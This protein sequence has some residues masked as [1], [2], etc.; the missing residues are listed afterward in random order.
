MN[1]IL[2]LWWAVC[3]KIQDEIYSRKSSFK[4][5]KPFK[6]AKT[7]S[8]KIQKSFK[9]ENHSRCRT[10]Q[11]LE[12]FSILNDFCI[13]NESFCNLERFLHLEWTFSWINF[14]LNFETKLWP[15]MCHYRIPGNFCWVKVSFQVLK[16]SFRGLIFVLGLKCSIEKYII[17][18]NYKGRFRELNR[19]LKY[20]SSALVG[21]SALH[22]S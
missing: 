10:I 15:T 11:D 22:W 17:L 12:C 19:G 9:I 4:M 5:P 21:N 8:F 3:F 14:I 1:I 7:Q 2:P 16:T 18:W 13:L 6:I 20:L